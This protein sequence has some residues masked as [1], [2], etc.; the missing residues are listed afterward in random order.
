MKKMN[1]LITCIACLWIISANAQTV[2]WVW[3]K[4]AGGTSLDEAF[5]IAYDGNNNFYVAGFFSNNAIFDNDTVASDGFSG[6]FLACYTLNGN[7]VWINSAGGNGFTKAT[8]IELDNKG[9]I[10][11]GGNI[12]DSSNFDGNILVSKGSYDIFLAKYSPSGQQLWIDQVG[13]K[14]MEEIRGI[15]I[16]N[17]DNILITGSYVDSTYIGGESLISK[18]SKDIFVLKYDSSG[19]YKWVNSFGGQYYDECGGITVDRNGNSYVA[20][21]FRD[22]IHIGTKILVAGGWADVLITK[23]NPEGDFVWAECSYGSYGNYPKAICIDKEANIYMTG[24][25]GQ[26]VQFGNKSLSSSGSSDVFVS[27]YDSSGKIKWLLGGGG[28]SGDWGLGIDVNDIGEAFISGSFKET[29]YFGNTELNS[30]GGWD[31]YVAKCSINGDFEWAVSGGSTGVASSDYGN[32]LVLCGNDI[33]LIGKIYGPSTFGSISV[34][35]ASSA[36]DV[37]IGKIGVPKPP[38]VIITLHPKA[39]TSCKGDD[40]VFNVGAIGSNLVYQW[41]FNGAEIAGATDSFYHVNNLQMNDNGKYS[42]EISDSAYSVESNEANL[43]VGSGPLITTQPS[44]KIIEKG[45]TVTFKIVATG[46]NTEFQWQKNGNNL[47][48]E[49]ANTLVLS[50]VD[51]SDSGT[52]KCVVNDMCGTTESVD[53][54]LIVKTGS[55]I[56]LDKQVSNLMIYPN[57]CQGI[58]MV[59]LNQTINANAD[60]QIFSLN[61]QRLDRTKYAFHIYQNCIE[62]HTSNDLKGIYI[63]DIHSDGEHYRSLFSIE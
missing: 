49:T 42:C 58:F 5:A 11:V 10:Y 30:S 2:D 1:L 51:Y 45:K 57:P 26:S 43:T 48:G 22:T 32:D 15:A 55:G 25:Y 50:N 28:D 24:C 14:Y 8:H 21:Q 62:F 33:F 6:M 35:S 38:S 7:L 17:D 54:Y 61:G 37:I 40:V 63:L 59:K 47:T 56:S 60:I 23:I 18:G 41:K 29:S 9:N 34:Q 20:G 27:K 12:T 36:S 53:V 46:I 31:I 44:N 39:Q 4:S 16:D 52:Y 13:S 3:A 19:S